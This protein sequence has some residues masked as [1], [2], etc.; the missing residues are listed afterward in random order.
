MS[1]ID[2]QY[3]S[4]KTLPTRESKEDDT[5]LSD[6]VTG[7]GYTGWL[8]VRFR[9]ELPY[10][11]GVLSELKDVLRAFDCSTNRDSSIRKPTRGPLPEPWPHGTLWG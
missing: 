3:A 4:D 2:S 5:R 1:P 10:R 9:V 7:P 11:S 6:H 8:R